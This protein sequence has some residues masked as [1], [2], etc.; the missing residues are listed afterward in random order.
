MTHPDEGTL[1]MALDDAEVKGRLRDHLEVC[2]DCR[3]ELEKMHRD[4]RFAKDALGADGIRLPHGEAR[5]RLR[6][7]TERPVGAIRARVATAA[8]AIALIACILAFTP[9]GSMAT[10]LLNIFEPQAVQPIKLNATD[11]ADMV[12]VLSHLGTVQG[13]VNPQMEPMSSR[14]VAESAAGFALSPVSALPVGGLGTPSYA[15]AGSN[16]VSF[17]FSEAKAEAWEASKG[18]TLP[19]MPQ[20][21]DGAILNVKTHPVLMEVWQRGASGEPTLLVAASPDPTVTSTGPSASE[22]EGYVAGLPGVPPSVAAEILALGATTLPIPVGAASGTSVQVNG[23]DGTFVT[24]Q[25]LR[26]LIW[27]S[28]GMI[29]LVGGRL[30]E[31]ELLEVA[32][33]QK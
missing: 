33:S 6:A 20:G 27:Q 7:K 10:G 11:L 4:A 26:A 8:V 25:S 3:A 19:Q 32:Q 13:D 24:S 16:S 30:G 31:A 18:E 12:S 29:H 5:I 17:T 28:G 1:R 23:H 14:D 22:I 9:V 21:M 15:V 2:P